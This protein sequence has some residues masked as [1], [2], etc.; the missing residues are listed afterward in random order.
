MALFLSREEEN[1]L[2]RSNKK[3]K[4]SHCGHEDLAPVGPG[5]ANLSA[6]PKLSF[7]DKLIREIQSAYTQAFDFAAHMDAES[8]S[9]EEIDEVRQGFVA[10][11]LSKETKSCSRVP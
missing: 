4:E 6:L 7:K 2:V 1:E 5:N 10:I 3:V 9:N 11:N 8:D